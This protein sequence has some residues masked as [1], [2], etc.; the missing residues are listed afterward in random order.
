[1]HWLINSQNDSHIHRIA[2]VIGSSRFDREIDRFATD[3]L[4]TPCW[5]GALPKVAFMYSGVLKLAKL[6]RAYIYH[7]K[8]KWIGTN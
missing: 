8:V 1:M 7:W 4:K 3:K 5:R 2:F 6:I